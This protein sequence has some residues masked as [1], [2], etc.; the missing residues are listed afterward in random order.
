MKSIIIT[1]G[2]EGFIDLIDDLLASLAQWERPLATAVGL[3][4][5]GFSP[6]TATRLGA[7]VDH[8]VKPG[9]D[10]PVT[11]EKRREKPH[12]RAM[13]ARPFLRDYFPGYE[14]YMW[15]DADTWVQSRFAVDLFMN[16]SRNGKITLAPEEHPDY[17][18]LLKHSRWRVDRLRR[19]FPDITPEMYRAN[20]YYNAGVFAMEATAPHWQSWAE[21]F[22]R[23]LTAWPDIVTDQAPLNFAIWSNDLPVEPLPAICNWCC[24]LAFPELKKRT[25]K[26]CEPN[27]PQREIGIVHLTSRTKDRRFSIEHENSTIEFRFRYRDLQSLRATILGTSG[28]NVTQP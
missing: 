20:S 23:G 6:A 16:A 21:A 17:S 12:L 19:Y 14:K 8:M 10:L 11:E 13:T 28:Q 1:G 15:L 26:F 22:G 24:H 5:L 3:L 9:W 7:T 2:D 25:L 4:D 18:R 27:P